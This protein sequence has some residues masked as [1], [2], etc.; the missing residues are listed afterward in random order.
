MNERSDYLERLIKRG[1]NRD[2]WDNLPANITPPEPTETRSV[3]RDSFDKSAWDQMVGQ[4]PPLRRQIDELA[5]KHPTSPAAYED[6]FNLLNQGDPRFHARSEMKPDHRVQHAMMQQLGKA[7]DMEWIRQETA[8]DEYN[9]ALAMLTMDERMKDAFDHIQE[10]QE[11]AQALEEALREALQNAQSAMPSPGG[12]PGDAG[13]PSPVE[14]EAAIQALE[15]AMQAVADHEDVADQTGEDAAALLDLAASEARKELEAEQEIIKGYGLNKGQ[16]QQMPFEERR[17]L[18]ESLNRGR[19]ER[20]AK[21]LGTF[22]PV[23]DAE[24]RRKVRHAPAEVVDVTTGND[25][26][27]IVGAEFSNL[28]MPELEDLFWLRYAKHGLMQY[29]TQGAENA[30]QGPIIYLC[31]ESGSMDSRVDADGN[32]CEMWSKA[33]AMALVDQAR[34]SNRDFIYIGFA[35]RHEQWECRFEG[36]Q[37][38]DVTQLIQF[39]QHFFAGG[40]NY[41]RPLTRA[42]ELIGEYLAKRGQARPDVVLVTDGACR[43]NEDFAAQWQEVRERADVTCWGIQIGES[44]GYR[45]QLEL[46]VDRLINITALNASPEGVTELFR[47]I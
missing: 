47:S 29:E 27:R 2:F 43:V 23:A 39:A 38:A 45:G 20:L 22:R 16:L 41:E 32:T 6:L 1:R 42:M 15:Q 7:D 10:A 9:T 24:R 14:V 30:G 35:S 33:V 12:Q 4:L 18:M 37:T 28:A 36:G 25:L 17:R 21:M 3:R 5:E 19:M 34:R 13:E 31:D 8:Y 11:M 46:L 44:S 40:T 26:H